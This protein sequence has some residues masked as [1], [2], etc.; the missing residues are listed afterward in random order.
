MGHNYP[1]IYTALHDEYICF[2]C[3]YTVHHTYAAQEG[4][5]DFNIPTVYI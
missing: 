2:L 4:A 1:E 5:G 3:S